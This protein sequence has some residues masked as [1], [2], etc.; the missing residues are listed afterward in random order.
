MVPSQRAGNRLAGK[1]RDGRAGQIRDGGAVREAL[2]DGLRRHDRADHDVGRDLDGLVRQRV[3]ARRSAVRKLDLDRRALTFEYTG[4]IEGDGHDAIVDVL[5]QLLALGQA[6]EG[7]RGELSVGRAV[8]DLREQLGCERDLPRHDAVGGLARA[9]RAFQTVVRRLRAGKEQTERAQSLRADLG[10][11]AAGRRVVGDEHDV[12]GRQH[13]AFVLRKEAFDPHGGHVVRVGRAV[14]RLA[15]R[16]AAVDAHDRGVHPFRLQRDARRPLVGRRFVTHVAGYE[17]D[18]AD[19][20]QAACRVVAQDE[21]AVVRLDRVAQLPPFVEQSHP[22]ARRNGG[23]GRDG[24]LDRIA[25]D[26]RGR[27]AGA[28]QAHGRTGGHRAVR[29]GDHVVVGGLELARHAV[30]ACG[31]TAQRRRARR[32]EAGFIRFAVLHEDGYVVGPEGVGDDRAGRLAVVHRPIRARPGQGRLARLHRQR[33]GDVG[34]LVVVGGRAGDRDGIGPDRV[35]RFVVARD[36]ERAVEHD[37]VLAVHESVVGDARRERIAVG[38]RRVVGRDGERRLPDRHAVRG[39]LDARRSLDRVPGVPRGAEFHVVDRV[40]GRAGMRRRPS[41]GGVVDDDR[42]AVDRAGRGQFAVGVGRAVVDRARHVVDRQ[43]D[44]LVGQRH[45]DVLP[46]GGRIGAKEAGGQARR[47][48]GRLHALVRGVVDKRVDAVLVGR[49]GRGNLLV[50]QE[51]RHLGRRRLGAGERAARHERPGVRHAEEVR[52]H[53]DGDRVAVGEVVS[54]DAAVRHR[55]VLDG[56]PFGRQRLLRDDLHEVAVHVGRGG[57]V[58]LRRLE[59]ACQA[60]RMVGARQ[61]GAGLGEVAARDGDARV[62]DGSNGSPAKSRRHEP[63]RDG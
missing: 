50:P 9:E 44:F 36:L 59:A 3:T 21:R 38:H 47:G 54:R 11:R 1:V 16:H 19:R 42:V 18:R 56:G 62:A 22:R 31:G 28:P 48:P 37:R 45:V 23:V 4:R 57:R 17:V 2:H 33:A 29:V 63:A 41:E 26:E 34:N 5:A 13:E 12:G 14:V 55:D 58:A 10:G 6:V 39:G 7:Q 32:M 24:H 43:A 40:G 53:L 20:N 35:A 51:E 27:R 30:V 15:G 61:G 25:V 60:A 49:D 52:F 46:R 8:V